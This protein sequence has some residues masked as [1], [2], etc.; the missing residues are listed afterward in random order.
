L[1]FT[2]IGPTP[3]IDDFSKRGFGDQDVGVLTELSEKFAIPTAFQ[4]DLRQA[5]RWNVA[6]Q[7][8]ILRMRDGLVFTRA[9]AHRMIHEIAARAA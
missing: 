9:M 4:I 7:S 2:G 8:L 6:S 1:A 3:Q 5:L